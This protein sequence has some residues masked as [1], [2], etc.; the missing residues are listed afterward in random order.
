MNF[1]APAI[2]I[3]IQRMVCTGCGAEANA[4]CNCGKAYV[5]KAVR[6]A[7]AITAN[8]E[9]SNRQIADEIGADKVIVDRARKKLES[10]GGDMS[11]PA[12]VTGKDGKQYPAKKTKLAETSAAPETSAE[13]MK[14]AHAAADSVEEHDRKECMALNLKVTKANRE[15][16]LSFEELIDQIGRAR[17]MA[18]ALPE[19]LGLNNLSND[20]RGRLL[21][22]IHEAAAAWMKLSTAAAKQVEKP[23]PTSD[24]DLEIPGFLQRTAQ[25]T[26]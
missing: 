6:A 19:L 15:L 26:H 8:P 2:K 23:A 16:T 14:R 12:S 25:A 9:K 13:R 10:T 20:Q 7:E 17:R 11:P 18:E 1:S 3:S 21:A 22:A 24:N 5:P 4:S